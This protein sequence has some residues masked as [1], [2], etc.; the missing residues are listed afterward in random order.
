M[1]KENQ[2]I[3]FDTVQE[4]FDYLDCK[5]IAWRVLTENEHILALEKGEYRNKN[6]EFEVVN[7]DTGLFLVEVK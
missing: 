3:K 5:Y 4:I 6:Y 2:L 1:A 7:K